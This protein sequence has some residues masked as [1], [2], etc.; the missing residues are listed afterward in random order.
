MERGL[1]E[2]PLPAVEVALARQQSLA[3]HALGPLE[4]PAL[5]EV[6]VV[7]DENIPDEVG[8]IEQV[9]VLRAILKWTMSPWRAAFIRNRAVTPNW[10]R[11]HR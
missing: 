7:R 2:P 3:E 4:A 9:H 8:V 6:L 10:S 5:H 1:R 11:L